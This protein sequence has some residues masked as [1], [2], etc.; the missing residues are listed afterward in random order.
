MA[1]DRFSGAGWALYEYTE[2]QMILLDARVAGDIR[3]QQA[4]RSQDA[5]QRPAD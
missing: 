2:H 4:Q 1:T 5:I 3:E